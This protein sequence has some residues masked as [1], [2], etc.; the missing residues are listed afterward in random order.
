[1]RTLRRGDSGP[2]V[3]R[4]QSLLGAHTDGIFGTQ[5]EQS[6]EDFQTSQGILADGIVGRV[7]W[8]YLEKNASFEEPTTRQDVVR[9]T[10]AK[11]YNG[12]GYDNFRLREDTA[13]ALLR[14]KDVLEEHGGH[15]TSSG[16]L[17]GLHAN[18]SA[19][20]SA[21]SMHYVGR[22]FDLFVYSAMVD[23]HKDPFVCTVDPEDDRKFIVWA[24]CPTGYPM[25]LDGVT[26]EKADKSTGYPQVI[27]PTEGTFINL[28]EL[29][30]QE[31]FEPI[32]ARRSFFRRGKKNNG[33]A[34]W[35]HFQYE[36]GLE[37]GVTTFGDEL[38][39]VYPTSKLKGTPPWRYRHYVFGV[40]WF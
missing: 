26:Y 6:V 17:R 18:V 19:N 15:L 9:V 3:K 21:T 10:G 20:R 30:Q 32:S 7:T 40:D 5:T 27:V 4:L 25:K 13:L 36:E 39:K 14:A 8:S 31:G 12:A 1:M 22:A 33:G 28:T 24:R 35:W 38:L 2:E 23:P 37:K 34:E 16:G 11:P 29:L